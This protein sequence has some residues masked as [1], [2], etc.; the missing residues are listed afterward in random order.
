MK[1]LI[2]TCGWIEVLVD[3]PLA[4]VYA[5]LLDDLTEVVVPTALQYELY[6]WICRERGEADA[7]EVIAMTTAGLVRPLDTRVALLAAELALVHRLEMPDAILLAHARVDEAEL[8]TSDEHFK[9]LAGVRFVEG[10][11]SPAKP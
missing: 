4:D 8:V 3:G 9:G 10:P 7:V 6:R 1:R 2:D 5:P 11:A